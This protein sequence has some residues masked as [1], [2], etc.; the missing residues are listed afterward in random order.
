MKN[1]IAYIESRIAKLSAK[2]TENAA[3]INKWKRKL[4]QV[5]AAKGN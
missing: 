4:R 2:P 3:L 5:M 1:D